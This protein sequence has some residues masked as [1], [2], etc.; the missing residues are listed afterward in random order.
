MPGTPSP[1]RLTKEPYVPDI[2]CGAL[3]EKSHHAV[4]HMMWVWLCG[5]G[6]LSVGG[7]LVGEGGA[8]RETEN[9]L[10]VGHLLGFGLCAIVC[11]AGPLMGRL[12]LEISPQQSGISMYLWCQ[13]F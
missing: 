13:I 7:Q 3:F 1:Y 8:D 10:V 6:Y 9:G 5:C 4:L 2:H 12:S 11:R